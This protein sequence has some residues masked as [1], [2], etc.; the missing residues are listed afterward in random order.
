MQFFLLTLT[1]EFSYSSKTIK[2]F[3]S[4]KIKEVGM[5]IY[6]KFFEGDCSIMA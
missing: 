3:P 4:I 2:K 5:N 1:Y 6:M